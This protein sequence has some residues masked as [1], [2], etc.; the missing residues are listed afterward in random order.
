MQAFGHVGRIIAT[1]FETLD[2]LRERYKD[3]IGNGIGRAAK[4][5]VI[6]Q[7]FLEGTLKIRLRLTTCSIA[8]SL[9]CSW[10]CEISCC[11]CCVCKFQEIDDTI[12]TLEGLYTEAPLDQQQCFEHI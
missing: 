10:P 12:K 5:R 3:G 7:A 1:T 4:L 2:C 11:E 9:C 6:F 8:K